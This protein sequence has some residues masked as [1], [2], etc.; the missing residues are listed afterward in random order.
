V[1]ATGA[2]GPADS[3][4]E[5]AGRPGRTPPP[6][7]PGHSLEA[8]YRRLLRW[9]PASYRARHEDEILGVLMAA[10]HDGQRRPGARDR[11]DLVWSGLRIRIRTILR[12]AEG[13]SWQQAL[14][15]FAV[16]LP[17]LMVIQRAADLIVRGAEYHFG[18]PADILIGAYGDPGSYT[19]S[20]QLNPFHIAFTGNLTGAL[21]AGPLP[22]LILAALVLLGLRRAA[23][24]FAAFIPLAFLG[25]ALTSGYTLGGGPSTTGT[26][27][28]YGIEA[29]ALFAAPGAAAG[30][31]ALRL[32]P[33]VLLAVGT[34]A[35]GVSVNGGLWPLATPPARSMRQL[36]AQ[37]LIGPGARHPHSF[38]DR[39][40]GVGQGGWGQWFLIQGS[41]IVLIIAIS[42]FML[43][44][45]PVNRRVLILLAVPFVLES[46][47]YL[48]SLVNPPLP[49]ALGNAIASLP[50][51]ALL[52]V[53]IAFSATSSRGRA[54]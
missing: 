33:T 27:Y 40:L 23:A 31:R 8:G 45:S 53:A 5:G 29:L 54:A 4:G 7:R 28:A 9:Y 37:H 14:A 12:G 25:I 15:W 17:L 1:S 51:F 21:T 3:A 39:L 30:W 2:A 44:S 36:L 35:L 13:E 6:A 19:R 46:G 20:F 38:L 10:A 18:S 50:L 43:A 34:I 16:L 26:L 11:A 49:A 32:R 48:S 47:V 22:A 24:A 52:V 41:L 42:V